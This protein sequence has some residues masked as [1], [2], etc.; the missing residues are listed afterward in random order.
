MILDGIMALNLRYFTEFVYDVV[1]KKFK[2]AIG[3][4]S[5]GLVPRN[6]LAAIVSHLLMNFF[7]S[8]SHTVFKILK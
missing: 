6:F 4:I 3:Q 5:L 2:F 7:V 8:L 1:V